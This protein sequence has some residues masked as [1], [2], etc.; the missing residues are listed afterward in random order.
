MAKE[1][2]ERVDRF[3]AVASSLCAL[4]CAL[5]AFLPVIFAVLGLGFLLT[6]EAE[7]L[8]NIVAIL[9]G[10]WALG[11]A[12]R[13]HRSSGVLGLLLVGILGLLLSR[14]LEM[15][16]HSDHHG[17][18]AHTDHAENAHTDEGREEVIDGHHDQQHDDMGEEHGHDEH[19]E[20]DSL[21]ELGA[22]L[23]VLSGLL[24]FS[25]HLLNIRRARSMREDE[26]AP[27]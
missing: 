5:C 12:W 3:G 1:P 4:H 20:A 8:L 25:G 27:E 15:A 13:T 24:L 18:T 21:H 7:W 19:G 23:G 14:G 6:H 16:A 2:T 22:S 10:S 9:F 26:D 17:E 11:L